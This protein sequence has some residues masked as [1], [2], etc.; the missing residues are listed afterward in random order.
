MA[1]QSWVIFQDAYNVFGSRFDGTFAVVFQFCHPVGIGW[2]LVGLI[3]HISEIV[4]YLCLPFLSQQY[5]HV[6]IFGC[7]IL[8][9]KVRWQFGNIL[10]PGTLI[11]DAEKMDAAQVESV[12][13]LHAGRVGFVMAIGKFALIANQATG[14]AAFAVGIA[15]IVSGLFVGIL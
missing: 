11:V 4:C 2:L 15:A 3:V 10:L 6:L 8:H 14:Y 5:A 13:Q 12:A 9:F 7:E 1:F